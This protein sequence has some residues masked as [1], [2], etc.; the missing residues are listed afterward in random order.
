MS[1]KSQ[2]INTKADETFANIIYNELQTS[3]NDCLNMNIQLN[4]FEIKNSIAE[5]LNKLLNLQSAN[6]SKLRADAT[7][8]I[9]ENK[10]KEDNDSKE[11][12]AKAQEQLKNEFFVIADLDG[13][14]PIDNFIEKFQSGRCVELI[15]ALANGQDK[16]VGQALENKKSKPTPGFL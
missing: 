11:K 16:P 6:S 3:L 12:V 2:P 10:N 8:I 13:Q 14:D 4:R 1:S 5:T 7:T 15:Q 9:D